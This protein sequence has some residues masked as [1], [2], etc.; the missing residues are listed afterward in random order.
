MLVERNLLFQTVLILLLD[1][2]SH[3]DDQSRSASG[4]KTSCYRCVCVYVCVRE[5][6]RAYVSVCVLAFICTRVFVSVC[7]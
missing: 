7:V 2:S 6:V 1:S 5:C 4:N 3:V